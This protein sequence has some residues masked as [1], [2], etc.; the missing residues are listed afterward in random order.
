MGHKTGEHD[1]MK[2][3]VLGNTPNWYF[4]EL[5]RAAGT[6][7]ELEFVSWDR[8]TARVGTSEFVSAGEGP[9][10]ACLVRGMPNGSLEQVIFRMNALARWHA[11]G[12][13]V[14]NSPRSLEIAIDKYLSLALIRQAGVAVP[15]SIV[16]QTVEASMDAFSELDRDV[17]I[18]PVFGGEGRGMMR[19]SDPDLALRSFRTIVNLQGV[20][21]LQRFVNSNHQD[22][23]LLVIGDQVIGMRRSNPGDWRTNASRGARCERYAADEIQINL[24][25]TAA[26]AVGAH[27]AGVDLIDDGDGTSFVLEVNGVPGWKSV[28]KVQNINPARMMVDF[29]V[30]FIDG[31]AGECVGDLEKTGLSPAVHGPVT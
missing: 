23:R 26:R 11:S 22:L 19:V 7:H 13:P 16:C 9:F 8:L 25:K 31:R 28:G 24:A 4:E 30:D 18:K 17:V 12:M 29:V 6:Q 1:I 15:E 20:V 14:V 5:A 10:D 2:I 21:Y 27:I 3:A